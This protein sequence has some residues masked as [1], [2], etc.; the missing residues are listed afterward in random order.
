M[1]VSNSVGQ[2]RNVTFG[3]G[4]VKASKSDWK[5]SDTLKEEIINYAKEDAKK[6]VYMGEKFKYLR[7]SEVAKVAPDRAALMAT[8]DQA[9][10][11]GDMGDM[12]RIKGDGE[13]W[14]YVL[15]DIP[16]EAEFQ[17][18]G[19]GSAVHVY[20]ENGEEILTY[21][22]GVGWHEKESKAETIVHRSLRLTYYNAWQ[23]AKKEIKLNS[24]ELVSAD[25]EI[26]QHNNF[27]CKA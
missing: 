8:I 14:L 1:I 12:Q 15:F 27:D 9:I 25:G 18:V 17:S 23:D 16:Y 26:V 21:T 5:L 6:N 4:K 20:D 10:A 3:T 11:F 13:R 7:K 22:G 2:N 24:R 19:F